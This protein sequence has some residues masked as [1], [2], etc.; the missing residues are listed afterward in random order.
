MFHQAEMLSHAIR[1]EHSL[2]VSPAHL[3]QRRVARVRK[4]LRCCTGRSL[5]TRLRSVV[6]RP[7][8]VC[9]AAT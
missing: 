1:H 3:E 2:A 8:M 7:A 4:A 5:G 6:D 9:C